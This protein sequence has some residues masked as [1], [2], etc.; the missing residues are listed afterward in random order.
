MER[1]AASWVDEDPLPRVDL[2]AIACSV[3]V[4]CWLRGCC[5]I[6]LVV[7]QNWRR[8]RCVASSPRP[9]WVTAGGVC[10]CCVEGRILLPADWQHRDGVC[11]CVCEGWC[12]RCSS[13]LFLPDCL[14]SCSPRGCSA[15]VST[16]VS[17]LLPLLLSSPPLEHTLR[18]KENKR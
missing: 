7:G 6:P 2:W 18:K 17:D 1:G 9:R 14:V 4:V 11:V 3:C 16:N 5:R 8:W 15:L 10:V 13:V 12:G